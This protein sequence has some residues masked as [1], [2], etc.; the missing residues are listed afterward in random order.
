MEKYFN[1]KGDIALALSLILFV[2]LVSMIGSK[3]VPLF[4]H[5]EKPIND[6]K[7]EPLVAERKGRTLE[8]LN[9]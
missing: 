5:H 1:F 2:V 9:S 6:D 3:I 4:F 7:G 8:S